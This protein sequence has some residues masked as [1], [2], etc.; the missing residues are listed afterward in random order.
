MRAV[1]SLGGKAK[2]KLTRHET[3]EELK[4]QIKDAGGD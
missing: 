3:I 2:R 1:Y 4:E